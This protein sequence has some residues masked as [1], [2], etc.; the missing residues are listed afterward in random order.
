[1]V[2][3][4]NPLCFYSNILM[5]FP[6]FL[7]FQA[8]LYHVCG[9]TIAAMLCSMYYHMDEENH[10]GLLVDIAGVVVMI[11]C[12]AYMFLTSDFLITY[13]NAIGVVYINLALW[14]YSRANDFLAVEEEEGEHSLSEDD[15]KEYE[16]YHVGWHLLVALSCAAFVYSYHGA[17][18]GK[19]TNMTTNLAPKCDE[20]SQPIHRHHT[21]L[22]CSAIDIAAKLGER[23]DAL[24]PPSFS[25]LLSWLRRKTDEGGG[26]GGGGTNGRKAKEKGNCTRTE[27]GRLCDLLFLCSVKKRDSDRT[28]LRILGRSWKGSDN[29]PDKCTIRASSIA[30]IA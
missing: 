30:N 25:R 15:W 6:A 14:Y 18:T 12:F 10:H 7:A 28:A 23:I 8:G 19:K 4:K 26:G 17:K 3:I 9:L 21:R 1:M 22:Y 11:A 2:D 20:V 27:A 29:L 16:F 13:M 5:L 24:D